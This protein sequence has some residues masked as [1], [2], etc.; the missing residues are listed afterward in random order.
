MSINFRTGYWQGLHDTIHITIYRR[1][2]FLA[3]PYIFVLP[4][5][6]WLWNV[7]DAVSDCSFCCQLEVS[8]WSGHL[9]W[10]REISWSELSTFQEW[11][12]EC[13]LILKLPT[14]N[15]HNADLSVGHGRFMAPLWMLCFVLTPFLRMVPHK[16]VNLAV[17]QTFPLFKSHSG[18]CPTEVGFSASSINVIVEYGCKILSL[19][20]EHCSDSEGHEHDIVDGWLE[21]YLPWKCLHM[22][23]T[24]NQPNYPHD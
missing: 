22:T 18:D 4:P 14:W 8:V 2:D 20:K 11:R 23:S 15:L 21:A 24:F 5:F 17:G 16:A 19:E 10:K 7:Y 1:I 9:K 6:F 3:Q 13:F 12:N